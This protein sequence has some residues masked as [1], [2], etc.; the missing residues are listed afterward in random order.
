[1]AKNKKTGRS[2]VTKRKPRKISNPANLPAMRLRGVLQMEHRAVMAELGEISQK[3]AVAIATMD[4]L[5][6]DQTFAPVFLAMAQR[7]QAISDYNSKKKEYAAIQVK[8]A[9]RLKIELDQ[10]DQYTIN[11]ETGVVI[12]SPPKSN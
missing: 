12:Y 10:L 2:K 4:A 1:L 8:I 9:K 11:P 3:S 6:R 5:S 7:D